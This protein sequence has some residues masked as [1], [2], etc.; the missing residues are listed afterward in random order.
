MA[1]EQQGLQLRH[2]IVDGAQ[3]RQ[4]EIAERRAEHRRRAAGTAQLFHDHGD[5]LQ[6]AFARLAA[7]PRDA[8]PDQPTPDI[9]DG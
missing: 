3:R 5:L 9:R 4:Q 2:R 6:A 8:L 1:F 7:E